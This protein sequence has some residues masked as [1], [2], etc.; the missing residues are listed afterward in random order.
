V[1]DFRTRDPLAVALKALLCLLT[2]PAFFEEYAVLPTTLISS[3][4]LSFIFVF[5]FLYIY[6]YIKKSFSYLFH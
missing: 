6:I 3:S 4:K 5:L 1:F 2:W